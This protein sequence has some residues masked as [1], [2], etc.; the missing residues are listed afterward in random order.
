[1]IHLLAAKSCCVNEVSFSDNTTSTVTL[2]CDVPLLDFLEY[3]GKALTMAQTE[4]IKSAFSQ[5]SC[6][7]DIR[8][9]V[10]SN[11]CSDDPLPFK[12]LHSLILFFSK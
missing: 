10:L 8:L 11:F 5:T 2:R 9:N 7:I 6:K 3:C 12:L 1:M 4:A